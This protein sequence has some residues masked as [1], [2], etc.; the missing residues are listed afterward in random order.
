MKEAT[1]KQARKVLDLIADKEVPEDQLQ[2][3]LESGLLADLLDANTEAVNRE[4]FR[5]AIGLKPRMRRTF[6]IK[7]G[8]GHWTADH[9]RRALRDAGCNTSDRADDILC[10]PNFLNSVADEKT[11]VDLEVWSTAELTGKKEGVTT[12]EVFAG[13]KRLGL[14]KCLAEVG[15][16]FGSQDRIQPDDEPL[17]IGMEPIAGFDGGLHVFVVRRDGYGQRLDTCFAG[18]AYFWYRDHPWLF[19][20]PRK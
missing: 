4:D 1:L 9:F 5:R 7:L 19:V 6:R 13:A 20:R 17:L 14:E 2:K 15:P 11:E 8:T 18:S 10:Q 3:L 12:T 16:Q